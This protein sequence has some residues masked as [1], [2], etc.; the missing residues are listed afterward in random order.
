MPKDKQKKQKKIS[1]HKRVNDILL[2]PLERPALIWLAA[3]MPQ[4]VSPDLL[5]LI[6]FIA[7]LLI[8][9]SYWLT[10]FNKNYLWLAN[11]GFVL[12]WFGDSLDGN[13]ARYRK[14]ERPRYGFFIDHVV[15]T[16]SE[17]A[18]FLGLAYSPYVDFQLGTLA[19]IAYLCMT[20]QVY[21][22][23]C[24]RR[25]FRISYGKLG[26]T[27]ARLI[28]ISANTLIFFAGN[29]LINIPYIGSVSL[30][31]L[32]V[33]GVALLLFAIFFSTAIEE[34]KKLNRKDR[35]KW[36]KKMRKAKKG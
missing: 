31:N 32:I 1:K 2:G 5:T 20:I 26:P 27:E 29:P 4:W 8:A 15:D 16:V 24:V 36:L 11:F 22:T 13:L 14:I 6:G 17:V 10:N 9:V 25:V 28:A 34:G 35:K 30:Y 19:L 21:I 18:I 3:H 12:N 7:A 33:A 23:T